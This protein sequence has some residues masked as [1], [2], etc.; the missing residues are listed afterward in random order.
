M[1]LKIKLIAKLIL[2]KFQII[3]SISKKILRE[4]AD[5]L[6]FDTSLGVYVFPLELDDDLL[7]LQE[8]S[9][10]QLILLK[11]AVKLKLKEKCEVD[12]QKVGDFL[13]IQLK[14]LEMESE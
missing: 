2:G 8:E 5:L 10:N 3:Y 13:V 6:L 4:M 12:I 1:L 9:L 7:V 14:G 11:S